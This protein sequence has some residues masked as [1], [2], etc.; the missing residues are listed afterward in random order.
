MTARR[1]LAEYILFD[2]YR[3]RASC[4]TRS[5]AQLPQSKPYRT[6]P[7]IETSAVKLKLVKTCKKLQLRLVFLSSA[8]MY[9]GCSRT[10]IARES[11]PAEG[12][13]STYRSN[14]SRQLWWTF[15]GLEFISFI[16]YSF[17]IF[18]YLCWWNIS[19]CITERLYPLRKQEFDLRFEI[20]EES[21][22]GGRWLPS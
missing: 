11:M 5:R 6:V 9:L 18:M 8:A 3:R 7:T 16:F 1:V 19:R 17:K 15:L 20:S 12:I 10:A 21:L 4:S 14:L 2:R 13:A 22:F